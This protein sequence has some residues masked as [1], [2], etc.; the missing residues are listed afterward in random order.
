M[1]TYYVHTESW[2]TATPCGRNEDGSTALHFEDLRET[3]LLVTGFHSAIAEA[4]AQVQG[5][6]DSGR[7]GAAIVRDPQLDHRMVR[8]YLA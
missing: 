2:L 8:H 1:K 4:K 5:I 7:K 6:R 3:A